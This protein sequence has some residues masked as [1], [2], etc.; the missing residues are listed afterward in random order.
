MYINKIKNQFFGLDNEQWNYF[1]NSIDSNSQ[2]FRD[3]Q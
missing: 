1:K 3:F 2:E